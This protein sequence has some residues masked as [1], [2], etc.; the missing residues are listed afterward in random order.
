MKKAVSGA[1]RVR[2]AW[3][4][5][6]GWPPG[7][8]RGLP[9]VCGS[10]ARRGARG[11]GSGPE[12]SAAARPPR[13]RLPGCLLRLPARRGG[14]AGPGPSGASGSLLAVLRTAVESLRTPRPRPCRCGGRS[15]RSHGLRLA[16]TLGILPGLSH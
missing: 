16:I 13:A 4:A 3:A 8:R 5:G 10:E 15:G 6:G 12:G 9:G 11:R 14:A 1:L 7:A 2:D